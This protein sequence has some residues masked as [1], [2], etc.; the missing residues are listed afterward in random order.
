MKTREQFFQQLCEQALAAWERSKGMDDPS[1]AR[2]DVLI[3][4]GCDYT[5]EI[6]SAKRRWP[7]VS[8]H[9]REV[10]INGRGPCA[11]CGRNG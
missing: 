7:E 10:S 5:D 2:V 3:T 11:K 1:L 9:V 6:E 4:D 8:F